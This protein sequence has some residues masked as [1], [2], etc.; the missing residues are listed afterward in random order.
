M[1]I[2]LVGAGAVGQAYGRHLRLGGAE[3]AFLVREKY[4]VEA[5]RGFDLYPL[6][7]P[8][9]RREPVRFDDFEVRTTPGGRR[10]AVILCVSS[11][12]LRAGAWV[13]ELARAHPD[14]IF[15]TLQPGIEDREFLRRFVAD[16]RLVSGL[17]A[18]ISYLAP[19][20]GER[21]PRPGV[22][23]WVPPLSSMPFSGTAAKPIIDAFRRGGIRSRR[24]P[25]VARLTAFS[26][27][28]VNIHM[29]A[30]EC[31]GWRF[32]RVRRHLSL[33]HNALR[34]A[35]AVAARHEGVP[36]PSWPRLL[37]PEA[38]RLAM[39]LAPW[40]LPLDVETYLRV[41]FTKVGDQTRAGLRTY[42]DLAKAYRLPHS[43]LA[44]LLR[45]LT[46]PAS[47]GSTDLVP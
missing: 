5:R 31:A 30:L 28:P 14:A 32:A 21:V 11:T 43:H 45:R 20:P 1:R 10:D 40:I 3:I 8:C 23:Y 35:V 34:E 46:D 38:A 26:S 47:R 41:H 44:E 16:E 39:E 19:L 17:I 12:A 33:A 42:V 36:P 25:D 18:I 2:L 24:H 6:N 29:A 4:A 13:A 37:R 22:A 7:R 9:P 27:A 15:V